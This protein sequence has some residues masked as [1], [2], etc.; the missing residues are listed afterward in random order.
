MTLRN[1]D[2]R[3]LFRHLGFGLDDFFLLGSCPCPRSGRSCGL[4]GVLEGL[5]GCEVLFLLE[6]L[7][8]RLCEGLAVGVGV[9]AAASPTTAPRAG[10]PWATGGAGSL[11]L[12]LKLLEW[13]RAR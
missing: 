11:S 13:K 4:V 2:V 7:E 1:L 12:M 3:R 10:T 6:S 9:A 5:L 8:G